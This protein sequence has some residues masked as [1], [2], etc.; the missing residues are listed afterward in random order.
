MEKG[1]NEKF[2]INRNTLL[3]TKQIHNKDLLYSTGNY[4]QR[5]IIMHNGKEYETIDIYTYINM[6]VY[7]YIY[8]Y[9]S[10]S[11][12]CIPEANTTL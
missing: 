10:E 1:I 5:L 12:C 2:G 3:Y 11:L 8:I 9:I 4:S 7:A 6:H